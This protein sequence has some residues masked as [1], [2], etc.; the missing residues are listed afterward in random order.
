MGKGG[1]VKKSHSQA[2]QSPKP[3]VATTSG[4]KINKSLLDDELEKREEENIIS[5]VQD[6]L[7][8]IKQ[9]KSIEQKIDLIADMIA[10]LIGLKQELSELKDT[11]DVTVEAVAAQQDQLEDIAFKQTRNNILIKGLPLH[12]KSRN[13]KENRVQTIEVTKNFCG[14]LKL[15][16][17][18]LV[19]NVTRFQVSKEKSDQLQRSGK[20]LAPI[21][22]VECNNEL[23]KW[24]FF[25]SIAKL[26]KKEGLKGIT[27]IND[28]PEHLKE[29]YFELDKKAFRIRQE[30]NWTKRTR[31]IP[32]GSQHL[33]LLVDGKEIQVN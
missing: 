18:A 2:E 16:F 5:D 11:V 26:G 1:K 13:N 3:M 28:Y 30:S 15:D 17:H 7:T 29:Q 32:R 33:A 12:E 20:T 31:I 10:S 9:K 22:K 27:L 6:K 8:K 21:I 19:G 24:E 4:T 23:A 14:Q 25:H